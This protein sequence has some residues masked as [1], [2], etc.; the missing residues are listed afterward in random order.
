[1][2]YVDIFPEPSIKGALRMLDQYRDEIT[3]FIMLP[4]SLRIIPSLYWA[5][6]NFE[7]PVIGRQYG[8]YCSDGVRAMRINM[9]PVDAVWKDKTT[10]TITGIDT[11][12]IFEVVG[13]KIYPS[14]SKLDKEKLLDLTTRLF[15][16]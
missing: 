9:K 7:N 5:A 3:D 12:A 4:D 8:L 1:M 11:D 10:L 15:V 16:K 6:L 13:Q 2:L 14:S